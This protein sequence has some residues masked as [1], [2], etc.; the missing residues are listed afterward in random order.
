MFTLLFFAFSVLIFL[1]LKKHLLGE[2]LF[3][4]LVSS[5]VIGAISVLLLALIHWLIVI[6]F[7]PAVIIMALALLYKAISPKS[8]KIV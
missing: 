1:V 2:S 7:W 6:L 4:L 5:A 3:F 8:N